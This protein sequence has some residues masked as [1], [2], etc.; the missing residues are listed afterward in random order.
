MKAI[1]LILAFVV[2]LGAIVGAFYLIPDNGPD[3]RPAI[4][5]KTLERLSQQF[6]NDWEQKGDW[7]EII[8]EDHVNLVKQ[9]SVKYSVDELERYNIQTAINIVNKKIFEE[10]SKTDCDSRVVDKYLKAI[11]TITSEDNSASKD[12]LVMKIGQVNDTYRK[13]L[14]FVNYKA[15]PD[16][17]FNGA[18]SSWNSFD[19]YAAAERRKR[20]DVRNNPNYRQYLANITS[21][22]NG[23]SKVDTELSSAKGSFYNKLAQQII[24]YYGKKE[25]I[26]DNLTALQYVRDKLRTESNNAYSKVQ[27]FALTFRSQIPNEEY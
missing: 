19:S 26:A 8:F 12:S 21:I 5:D 17:G 2:I 6:K 10:W 24:S 27:E 14:K 15:S 25:R 13:A 20:D 1:K 18:R 9:K 16:P 22:S 11:S 4:P 3:P 23:L 7:D